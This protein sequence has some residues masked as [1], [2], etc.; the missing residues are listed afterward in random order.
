MIENAKKLSI[1]ILTSA[2]ILEIKY[3][4][5]GKFAV[6]LGNWLTRQKHNVLLMGSGFASVK[7][8]HLSE[9][10]IEGENETVPTTEQKKAKILYPP[11]VVFLI[12]RIVMSLLWILRIVSINLKS[13]ISIIHAQDTGYSGLAAIVAG[14]ILGIPVVIS[15]HGVR[16]KSVE[17]I[18]KGRLKGMLMKIEYNLDMFT[19]KNAKGVIVVN[20]SIKRY[21]EETVSRKIDFIPI[22]IKTKNFQ[23][24][25]SN[26]DEIRKELG[27]DEKTV[28]MGFVGRFSAEKNLITLLESFAAIATQELSFTKLVLVGTGPLESEIKDYISK[29]SIQDK[30]I[31]FGV[32]YDISRILSG[33]DIFILPSYVEGLSVAL[34]EAMASGRA[35]ICSNIDANRELIEH[36]KEGLLVDPYRPCE[37][38]EAIR[39]LSHDANL[40]LKLG[41]N[42]RIKVKQYDETA[43]FP[44]IE[45]YYRKL[46][47]NG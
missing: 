34:L 19:V 47:E 4:G 35:I 14:R 20:P 29:R 6:L 37:F 46:T 13:P 18:V 33:I 1:C 28:I 42:A 30:V 8:L 43:I 22:P 25:E 27:V 41:D 16:H 44:K 15:S 40:R 21:F 39:L 31:L 38:E 17:S 32:R 7:T 36:T 11:Y 2:R 5:E 26:R 24:S 3:G 10:Y 23:F 12:S 9:A 45:E